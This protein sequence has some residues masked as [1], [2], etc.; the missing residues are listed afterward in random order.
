[1]VQETLEEAGFQILDV[2]EMSMATL[3][4]EIVVAKKV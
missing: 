1:L 2:T 3:P 4:V